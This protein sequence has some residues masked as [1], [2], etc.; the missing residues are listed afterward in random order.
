MPADFP[1]WGAVTPREERMLWLRDAIRGIT[2]DLRGHGIHPAERLMLNA[3]RHDYRAE[4]SRL[5]AMTDD[6]F[7]APTPSED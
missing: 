5:E 2:T 6:A 4:L 7:L 3:E 1:L